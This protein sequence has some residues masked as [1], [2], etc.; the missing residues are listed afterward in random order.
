REEGR[1]AALTRKVVT[2]LGSLVADAM[3]RGLAAH[4]PVRERKR[5]SKATARHRVPLEVG[6]HIP[7]PGEIRTLLN[8]ASGYSRALFATAALAGLR[9]SELRG[10]AWRDVDFAGSSITVRQRAD[11]WGTL[12][13]PKAAASRRTIPVPSLVINALKEWKVA[14]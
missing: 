12:G 4:N 1:S 9:L 8:A 14:C 11:A 3:E 13:S 2:S 7:T 10:L 5:R 6:V